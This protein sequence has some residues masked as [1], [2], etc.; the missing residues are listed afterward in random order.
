MSWTLHVEV[1]LCVLD[2]VLD[3]ACCSARV[4]VCVCVL[5]DIDYLSY[6]FSSAIPP[7]PHPNVKPMAY[8][9]SLMQMGMM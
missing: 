6:F 4:C 5:L 8:A 3:I 9:N 7:Q 2:N 1:C